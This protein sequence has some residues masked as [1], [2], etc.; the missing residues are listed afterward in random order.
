MSPLVL[1]HHTMLQ[2]VCEQASTLLGRLLQ[3]GN[4]RSMG[5]CILKCL[6][7][8]TFAKYSIWKGSSAY[9]HLASHQSAKSKNSLILLQLQA[10]IRRYKCRSYSCSVRLLNYPSSRFAAW[11]QTLSVTP[12]P[13]LPACSVAQNGVKVNPPPVRVY[14]QTDV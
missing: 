2:G 10:G 11:G 6:P 9:L 12:S 7:L 13:L 8:H 1:M 5:K 3:S 4:G 14:A